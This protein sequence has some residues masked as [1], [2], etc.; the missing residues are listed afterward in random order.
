MP[1]MADVEAVSAVELFGAHLTGA[2][3]REYSQI[4]FDC[5]EKLFVAIDASFNERFAKWTIMDKSNSL[6]K[7]AAFD[8]AEFS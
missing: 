7:G 8:S 6:L 1:R 3:T 4:L 2:V 5:A